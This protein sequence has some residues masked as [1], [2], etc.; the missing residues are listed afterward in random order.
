MNDGTSLVAMVTVSILNIHRCWIFYYSD[1]RKLTC[2]FSLEGFP[3]WRA[4]ALI[5]RTLQRQRGSEVWAAPAA[6]ETSASESDWSGVSWQ[7]VKGGTAGWGRGFADKQWTLHSAARTV[8]GSEMGAGSNTEDKPEEATMC[9]RQRSGNDEETEGG[10][11]RRRGG[12]EADKESMMMELTRLVQKTVKESSWWERR[13]IDCSI[14]AAAFFCLPPG[15]T[16]TSA[17]LLVC[18]GVCEH[19]CIHACLCVCEREIHLNCFHSYFISSQD[20]VPTS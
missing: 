19:V 16:S 8:S 12:E 3:E 7:G 5:L 11:Q 9:S 6:V 15:K 13:G 10:R 14:L 1:V 18:V 2:L 17:L 4:D 20:F